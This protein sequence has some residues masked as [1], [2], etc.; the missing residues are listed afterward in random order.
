MRI[1]IITSN[2]YPAGDAGAVRQHAMAGMMR[3]RGHEV[4]V[5]GYGLPADGQMHVYE[6]VP[7]VS[8]RSQSKN[9]VIRI[10]KR[11]SFGRRA[12]RFLQE[13]HIQADAFLVVDAFPAALRAIA[14]YARKQGIMLVHDSVEW[15]SPEEFPHGKWSIEYRHKE[16]TNLKAVGKDWRV[17]AISR[18]LEQHFSQRC[19]KVARIPVVMDVKN[20]SVRFDDCCKNEKIRFVYAGAPGRK[21]LIGE[22]VEGVHLLDNEIR[23]SIEVYLI[24]ITP[25][26]LQTQ[27]GVPKHMVDELSGIVMPQGRVSR[28][29]ALR[30]VR[31]ADYTLLVR[32]EG[33]RYAKAGFP[34]KVVE[35]LACGTPVVCNM[36]SDL[37]D[38]LEDGVNA[39]VVHGHKPDAVKNALERIAVMGKEQARKM[40]I[41]ARNTAEEYFDYRRYS[42][43]LNELLC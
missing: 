23:Q 15:Y 22:I 34:T 14:A 35:S 31:E 30:W 42:H 9:P 11:Y 41:P 8:M 37:S 28:D 19:E 1:V 21:D 40:R 12:V 2:K 17:I 29:I 6:Q 10:L 18:Y 24:G 20:T 39:F 38:Y 7:Y 27:C 33:L 13:Q 32:H 4:L 3:E 5:V 43:V 26:Q 36:S 16:Y 25:E